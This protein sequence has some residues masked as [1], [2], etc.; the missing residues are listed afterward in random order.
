MPKIRLLIACCSTPSRVGLSYIL[1]NEKGFLIIKETSSADDTIRHIKKTNP[2]II[3]I[4]YNLLLESGADLIKKI[5]NVMQQPKIVLFNSSLTLDQESE[6][7]REGVMGILNADSPPQ[8]LIKAL[9]KIHTGEFW[10]RRELMKS[11]AGAHLNPKKNKR[12]GDNK[13]PLTRREI[14]ILTQIAS[15]H[16]NRAISSK[17]C[18]SEVTPKTHINNIY[19]KLEINDRFQAT[20]GALKHNLISKSTTIG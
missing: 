19:K 8:T 6:L 20:L 18:I 16:K 3:L 15:G 14:E 10:L 12:S 5:N 1:S 11:L 7:V 13:L 4:C 2:D 17:L 9:R